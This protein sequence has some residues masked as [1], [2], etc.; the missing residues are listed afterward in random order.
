MIIMKY[1]FEIERV[2]AEI[3]KRKA[4]RALIQLPEGLKQYARE[5]IDGINVDCVLSADACFGACDLMTTPECDVTV[6]FGHSKM[7]ED[8]NVIYVETHSELDVTKVIEK[9]IPLL[10]KRVALAT[11]A[12][13]LYRLDEMKKTLERHGKTVVLGKTGLKTK[14]GQVLGCDFSSVINAD[15]D[16]VLFVGSG[17]FHPLGVA[18]FTNKKTIQADPYSN[19]VTVIDA[20]SWEKEKMLRKEKARNAKTFGIIYSQKPGQKNFALAESLKKIS[21]KKCY[22]ISLNLI[23]PDAVDYLPF[24]AYVITAC[25]RI[26]LDDWKNFKKPVLL[27][28]EFKELS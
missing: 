4:K 10:G 19:A 9:A 24:D 14:P 2:N 15:A 11:T 5:I 12:Q 3:K 25:P 20:S 21:D 18:F 6:H 23:T 8:K 17:R 26:V 13:H 27:P 1:D 7:L 28:D 16:C 22:L